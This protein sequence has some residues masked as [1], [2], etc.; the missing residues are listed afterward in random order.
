M[1]EIGARVAS[2]VSS[3]SRAWG[4]GDLGPRAAG[5]ECDQTDPFED[6]VQS[7]QLDQRGLG[8]LGTAMAGWSIRRFS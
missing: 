2:T 6:S 1:S 4:L 7:R 3:R 8:M 5:A